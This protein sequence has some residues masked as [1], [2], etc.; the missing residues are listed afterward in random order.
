MSRA[1]V[2]LSPIL[3]NPHNYFV[4]VVNDFEESAKCALR[5]LMAASESLR[6]KGSDPEKFIEMCKVFGSIIY[7]EDDEE[8]SGEMI[9]QDA[10][11]SSVVSRRELLVQQGKRKARVLVQERKKRF[12]P[13]R[14][15]RKQEKKIQ[16]VMKKAQL[17]ELVEKVLL[18]RGCSKFEAETTARELIAADEDAHPSHG[19]VRLGK[20]C[21]AI[22][23]HFVKTEAK[24][25][26]KS[27]KGILQVHGG[28]GLAFSARQR[29]LPLLKKRARKYGIATLLLTET[30][31]ISGRLAP[32]VEALALDDFIA[33]ACVN[34]PAYVCFP[35]SSAHIRP[36][37]KKEHLLNLVVPVFGTN[38]IAFACPTSTPDKPIVVDMA[39]SQASRGFLEHCRSENKSLRPGIAVDAFGKETLDA[40]IALDNGAQLPIAGTKGALLALLIEILAGALT[41]SDLATDSDNYNVMNRGSFILAIDARSINKFSLDRL[42]AF[43]PRIPGDSARS[44]R[45]SS[46]A[47]D[48]ISINPYTLLDLAALAW[49]GPYIF[50]KHHTVLSQHISAHED[51]NYYTADVV[52]KQNET[53]RT[54]EEEEESAPC[55]LSPEHDR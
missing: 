13:F 25:R 10:G 22:D 51:A 5:I 37:S 35:P 39:T 41:H 9:I 48:G 30:H 38:P 18:D 53:D 44:A 14:L 23:Q 49:G 55:L 54:V 11:G 6:I 8:N 46:A 47:I 7:L 27:R 3:K 42:L 20:I 19:L 31:S 1:I 52:E 29:A 12:V 34:S 17:N 2:R 45:L 4:Q 50:K 33:I 28:G 16:V 15:G 32:I 24:I 36:R 40:A 26:I 43:L 21:E